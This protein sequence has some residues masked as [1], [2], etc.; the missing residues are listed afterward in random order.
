[1]AS[2]SQSVDAENIQ[3]IQLLLAITLIPSCTALIWVLFLAGPLPKRQRKWQ[4]LKVNYQSIKRLGT[5]KRKDDDISW[6][7]Q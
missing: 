5:K 2:N 4:R 6:A 3:L 1:M 7:I